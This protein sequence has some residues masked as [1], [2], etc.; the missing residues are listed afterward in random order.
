MKFNTWLRQ[1]REA[2]GW[3]R[4][5][6]AEKL[7]VHMASIN[8]YETGDQSPDDDKLEKIAG[9]FGAEFKDL[10]MACNMKTHKKLVDLLSRAEKKGFEKG[11]ITD[12]EMR[13]II[14]I[15]NRHPHLKK[16]ALGALR[17]LDNRE[18]D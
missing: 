11:S 12:P 1:A 13:E 10:W 17:P 2:K 5:A 8:N 7:G 14:D 16:V 18:D 15:L 6:M 3:T 4:K 9:L